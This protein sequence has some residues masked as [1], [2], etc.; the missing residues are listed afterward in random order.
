MKTDNIQESSNVEDRRGQTSSSNYGTRQSGIGGAFLPLLLSRFGWKGKIIII[1]AFLLFGGGLANLGGLMGTTGTTNYQSAYIESAPSTVSDT[2]ALFMSKVLKTTEDFWTKEF[3]KHNR[4]YTPPKLVF[5]TGRIQTA[6]GV[7][8]ADG[9][10]FYCGADQ[11]IYID[12]SF[13]KEL[14]TRYKAKGDFAMAYVI[15]HEVGHH[16]QQQLGVLTEFHNAKKRLSEKDGNALTV[17]LELQAD[18]YAGAWA[19]YVDGQGLLDYGDI[20][21][22]LTAARAVGDDTLQKQTYGTVMPDSFTHGTSEQRS[23]WFKRGYQYG[24]IKNG[25]TFKLK[26]SEL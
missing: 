14:S 17:K 10:P 20:E 9:G 7:G 2:E 15:A 23:R 25:D 12:I 18:Y 19:K 3:K 5:Y 16:V 21:E 8:T 24:D 22:A 26:N 13:Y 4:T 11:K 6:C 1:I